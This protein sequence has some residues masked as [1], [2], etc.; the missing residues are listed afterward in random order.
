MD[1]KA[2]GL[3]FKGLQRIRHDWAANTFTFT[4][5]EVFFPLSQ[6]R[7]WIRCSLGVCRFSRPTAKLPF[8]ARVYLGG[9]QDWPQPW[10]MSRT[11]PASQERVFFSFSLLSL[12]VGSHQRTSNFHSEDGKATEWEGTDPRMTAWSTAPINCFRLGDSLYN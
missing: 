6:K 5:T 4:Q 11:D 2:G 8:I 3:Q 7:R 1:G 12:T 10:N 9:A